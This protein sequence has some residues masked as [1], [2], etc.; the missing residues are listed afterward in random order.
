MILQQ[1]HVAIDGFDK[2]TL[3]S[4]RMNQPDSTIA[5]RRVSVGDFNFTLLSLGTIGADGFA[6]NGSTGNILIE[7]GAISATVGDGLNIVN[8]GEFTMNNTAMTT[9][10]GFTGDITG[11][12]IFGTDNTVDV[13]S[14]PA[15]QNNPGAILFNGGADQ[16]D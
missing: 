13:F 9:I 14:Q 1:L 11:T 15:L 5:G 7:D 16:L 10:G 12:T 4:E 3:L 6:V 2:P 8:G